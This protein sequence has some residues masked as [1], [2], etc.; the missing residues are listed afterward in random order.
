MGG[1]RLLQEISLLNGSLNR[2]HNELLFCDIFHNAVFCSC[3][4]AGT[5]LGMLWRSQAQVL[6]LVLQIGRSSTL[7]DAI[8][9]QI[10][11]S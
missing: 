6:V 9:P 3:T 10:S 4:C 11:E 7:L 2:T 8:R 5:D 1:C